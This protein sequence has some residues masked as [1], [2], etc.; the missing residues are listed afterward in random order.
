MK[1]EI[2]KVAIILNGKSKSGKDT[3]AKILQQIDPSFV[4]IAFA[5]EL[6]KKA[7]KIL[8]ITLEELETHKEQYRQFLIFGGHLGR[9]IDPDVWVKLALQVPKLPNRIVIT[10]CRFENEAF[11][12]DCLLTGYNRLFLRIETSKENQLA[13]GCT[14]FEDKSEN[15]LDLNKFKD[16]SEFSPKDYK[17]VYNDGTLEDLTE[18]VKELHRYAVQE[19]LQG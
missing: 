10:D 8:G 5:D 7:A 1:K 9:E 15:D 13:R 4:R 6:K 17:I 14:V 2:K 11:S 16:W 18:A 12:S 19:K 3:F